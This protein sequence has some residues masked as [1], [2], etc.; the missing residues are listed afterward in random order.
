MPPRVQVQE[1]PLTVLGDQRDIVRVTQ[2]P[3]LIIVAKYRRGLP[4]WI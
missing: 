3:E 2:A 1:L 4:R